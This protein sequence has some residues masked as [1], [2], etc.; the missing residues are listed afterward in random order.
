MSPCAWTVPSAHIRPLFWVKHCPS[1]V[2]PLAL[3]G[4][5]PAQH[6]LVAF[7]A[8]FANFDDHRLLPVTALDV[9]V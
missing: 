3:A 8:N 2:T 1:H 6:T 9:P 7:I 5:A 4:F